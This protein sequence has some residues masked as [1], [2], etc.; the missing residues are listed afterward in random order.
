MLWLGCVYQCHNCYTRHREWTALPHVSPTRPQ[1]FRQIVELIERIPK[2]PPV[3]EETL[4][5]LESKGAAVG[6]GVNN[7]IGEHELAAECLPYE[8]VCNARCRAGGGRALG[9]CS[10]I[11]SESARIRFFP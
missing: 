4:A 6:D 8:P 2:V 5:L 1:T 11:C 10:P 7:V 9:V 3:S